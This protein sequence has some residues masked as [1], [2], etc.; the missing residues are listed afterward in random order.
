M[1]V[2]EDQVYRNEVERLK[3]IDKVA[4]MAEANLPHTHILIFYQRRLGIFSEE[5]S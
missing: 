5:K 1:T 3:K 4:D 2:E